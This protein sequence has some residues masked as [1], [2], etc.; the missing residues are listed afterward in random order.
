MSAAF[1]ETS[2][3]IVYWT[4]AVYAGLVGTY[5]LFR[6]HHPD[7]MW[8]MHNVTNACLTNAKLLIFSSHWAA[9]T[10]VEM[11][12]INQNKIKVV[13]FGANLDITHSF[14]DVKTM[15]ANR[16]TKT[17]KL[18]F[19]GKEWYRKGGDIV[20]AI[21]NAL[22]HSG[23]PVEVTLVGAAPKNETLPPYIRH[24]PFISK[25]NSTQSQQL[26]KLYQ[27]SHFLF[28]PSRAEAFGIVFCEANAFGVP[29]LTTYV[30][31]IP[32][33]IKNGVNGM[34]FSLEST[35]QHYCDY[36][37][38]LMSN[39]HE[40]EN[41]A[42]SAFNEYQTRLNWGCAAEKVKRHLAELFW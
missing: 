22:H 24:L 33:I 42:L 34:T 26:Q 1:L 39:R 38:N 19:V 16:S 23:Y 37:I 11:Y 14:D 25:N 18:L 8:D 6:S 29:C 2:V 21:A 40:Y 35:I 27:E 15:I 36:I 20:L 28:V 32:D 5:P 31:G 12:G 7:T 17:I 4:D 3:P 10:A 30:G 13:P 41:L 9:R